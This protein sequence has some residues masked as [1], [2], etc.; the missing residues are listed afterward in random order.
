M[1]TTER[2]TMG[3]LLPVIIVL[4]F[5]GLLFT[6]NMILAF[7]ALVIGVILVVPKMM[8]RRAPRGPAD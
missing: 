4:A 1:S 6:G 8:Q 3:W 5:V 7:A 2:K